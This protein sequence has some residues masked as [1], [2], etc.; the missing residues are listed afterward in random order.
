MIT[1]EHDG[2]QSPRAVPFC[3]V[4]LLSQEDASWFVIVPTVLS[5]SA[6]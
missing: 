5:S 4:R 3:G 1:P 6:G 2:E